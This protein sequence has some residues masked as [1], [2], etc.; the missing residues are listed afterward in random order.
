[1]EG[2]PRDTGTAKE[3]DMGG[4]AG[5]TDTFPSQGLTCNCLPHI[6]GA[7]L[8]VNAASHRNVSAQGIKNL[9]SRHYSALLH[10]G[11]HMG[12]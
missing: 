5:S 7:K 11:H 1:M 9:K 3:S 12:G 6:P 8:T 4:T 10:S 2:I